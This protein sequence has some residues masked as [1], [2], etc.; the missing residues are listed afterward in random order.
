MPLSHQTCIWHTCVQYVAQSF[1]RLVAL[2]AGGV[3]LGVASS[4]GHG[5]CWEQVE[6]GS[7]G[8]AVVGEGCEG[9]CSYPMVAAGILAD[10]VKGPSLVLGFQQ[11][12]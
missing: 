8:E 5:L 4:L 9:A 3:Y 12:C 7:D 2:R 10:E 6:A 11:A 1:R